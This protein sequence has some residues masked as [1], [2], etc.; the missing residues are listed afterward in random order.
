M[1]DTL[2]KEIQKCIVMLTS[3]ATE[4]D[5][6]PV[7]SH[8][9]RAMLSRRFTSWKQKLRFYKKKI[10]EYG[11]G[12]LI[13]IK[14]KGWKEAEIISKDYDITYVNINK[15]EAVKLLKLNSRLLYG[16]KRIE[17]LEIIEETT[18]IRKA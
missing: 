12:N 2:E 8:G 13:I 10:S 6:T 11:L 15:E 7:T 3:I 5:S 1:V 4:L 17:V 9:K 14:F 18:Q 16:L